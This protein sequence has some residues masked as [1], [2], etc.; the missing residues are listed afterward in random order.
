MP[1]VF[2]TTKTVEMVLRPCPWVAFSFLP[3]K[4][5]VTVCLAALNTQL[6]VVFHTYV[7]RLRSGCP[8]IWCIDM[9]N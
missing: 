7:L 5:T 2:T 6:W 9:Q 1:T 8:Q 3:D 4:C